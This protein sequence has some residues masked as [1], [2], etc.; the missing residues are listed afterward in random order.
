MSPWLCR[1]WNDIKGNVKYAI[2]V[3]L[4]AGVVTGTVALTHGLLVWQQ[5]WQQV[6]LAG[7]FV[8]L[9]GWAVFATARHPLLKSQA[10]PGAPS[11]PPDGTLK[12][13]ILSSTDEKLLDAARDDLRS[14]KF[15]H[16]VALRLVH[17]SPGQ[18]VGEYVRQLE[19]LKIA[20]G[21][22]IIK[23]LMGATVLIN[24]SPQMRLSQ[25][26]HAFIKRLVEEEMAKPGW[27]GI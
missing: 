17:N 16:R 21:D 22:K 3:V 6:G 9:F 26:P 12:A 27:A 14:L 11:P 13:L 25:S 23:W 24:S 20:D 2:L 5:V 19:T 7:C 4:G 10:A 1:Q 15:E 18:F 8:L